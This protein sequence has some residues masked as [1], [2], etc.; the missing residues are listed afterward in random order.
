MAN[1]GRASIGVASIR[2]IPTGGTLSGGVH[3]RGA[4]TRVQPNMVN[5]FGAPATLIEQ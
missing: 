3:N 4:P 1:T 5:L 2:R